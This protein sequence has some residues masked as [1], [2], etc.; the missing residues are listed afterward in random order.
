M[1]YLINLIFFAIV[2]I[3]NG[4]FPDSWWEC[5]LGSPL[6]HNFPLFSGWKDSTTCLS[7]HLSKLPH[8]VDAL[9][10]WVDWCLR[11]WCR[12]AHTLCCYFCV[13]EEKNCTSQF[14]AFS[15]CHVMWETSE[16]WAVVSFSPVEGAMLIVGWSCGRVLNLDHSHRYV[17]AKLEANFEVVFK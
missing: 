7:S 2:S 5:I 3:K 12:M 14:Y 8:I 4:I 17:E 15:L 9:I 13:L 11:W 6:H 16:I 1:G 10:G